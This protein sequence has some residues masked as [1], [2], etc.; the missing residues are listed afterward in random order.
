MACLADISERPAGVPVPQFIR[1]CVDDLKG[2][3]YE[4][5]MTQQ[6]HVSEPELHRWFWGE[7]AVA[8]LIRAVAQHK[9]A[10]DDP[11]LKYFANGL[12]R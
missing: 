9:N 10:S 2:F 1:Y 3:Y 12:A 5:P 8:Q 11:V 6:P 7:T 4:A